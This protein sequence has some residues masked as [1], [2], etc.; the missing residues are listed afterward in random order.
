MRL[1][2]RYSGV[3]TTILLT[4]SSRGI[5][6]AAK[7]SLEAR[8]AKVIGQATSSKAVDT[9]PA[10]FC[11]P[12]A[13]HELW[14][15]ALARTGG[16]ID[17]LINNAGLF[18]PNP[19]DRSDIEWLGAVEPVCSQALAGTRLFRPHR[20]RRQPSGP[21]RRFACPLALRREQGGDAG[22]AQDHRP[23]ICASGHPQL[24]HHT[25]IYGYCDGGRLPRKPWRCR[26][27]CRYSSWP[28]SRT[29]RNG[30]DHNLLRA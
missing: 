16:E 14:E 10:D 15:A 18:D 28:S 27:S 7:A 20:S 23:P 22:H 11:E 29:R 25:R 13:P 3:M 26:P 21:S 4:G 5:G 30:A 19:L 24:C 2:L 8:G 12:G 9:V 1:S 6:A 17:V